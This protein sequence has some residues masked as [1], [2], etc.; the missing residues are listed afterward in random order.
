MNS[1]HKPEDENDIKSFHRKIEGDDLSQ[2][3]D[4]RKLFVGVQRHL[5]A[6]FFS[7]VLFAALGG[8]I[9]YYYLTNYIASAVLF[10]KEDLPKTLPGGVTLNN[11]SLNT[12]LDIIPLDANFQAVIARLGLSLTPKVLEKMI[13]VPRPG[14]NS[15]LVRIE[16]KSDNPHLA[17]DI[18]NTLAKVAVKRSQDLFSQQLQNEL[19]GLNNQLSQSNSRLNNALDEIEK[20]KLEHHYFEMTADYTLLINQLAEARSNLQAANLRYN[21]LLVEYDNLKQAANA[22]PEQIE[23]SLMNESEMLAPSSLATLDE[24]QQQLSAAKAKYAPENPKIKI[25]QDQIKELQGKESDEPEGQ[26]EEMGPKKI[27]TKNVTKEKLG[28]ELMLMEGRVRSAKKT[29]EDL[30]LIL[31]SLEK[32]LETLPKDQIAFVKLLKAKEQAEGQVDFLNKSIKTIQLMSN[33]PTG[34][35]EIYELAEKAKPLK[36]SITVKLLPLGGVLFGLALGLILAFYLEMHDTKIRTLKQFELLYN[37]PALLFIPEIS[38][39]NKKNGQEKT[40]YF[41]RLLSERLDKLRARLPKGAGALI[42]GMMSSAGHEGKSCLAYFLALY[43]KKLGKKVLLIE[44]DSAYNPFNSNHNYVPFEQYLEG[45]A[46]LSSLIFFESVDRIKVAKAAT[47][48]KES[49]KSH[50][51]AEGLEALKDSYE[52]IIMDLPGVIE[53]DYT[54]NLAALCD[55]RIFIIGSSVVNKKLV[56]ESLRDLLLAGVKPSGVILNRVLPIYIEDVR[57]QL[58]LQKTKSAFWRKLF[59]I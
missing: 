8:V 59:R 12:A 55:L 14:S 46:P 49:V 17:V 50:Q 5:V 47:L 27:T 11:P 37:L 52:V 35:F 32:Q 44:L 45:S 53:T 51:M 39:L 28:L 54:V 26:E 4:T 16:C 1:A 2:N 25:L 29:K 21:S 23:G 10:Y 43:Y 18:A 41:M 20:F 42:V 38:F 15:S 22:M 13:S 19:N 40:L 58:E 9:S 48:M 56:D 6:I 31:A 24:L 34:C 3:Y 30:A 7:I 57:I 33:V 36:E